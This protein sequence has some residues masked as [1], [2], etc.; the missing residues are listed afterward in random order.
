METNWKRVTYVNKH[1]RT[2]HTIQS[3]KYNEDENIEHI[4]PR[5]VPLI[6]NEHKESEYNRPSRLT[7][8]GYNKRVGNYNRQTAVIDYATIERNI[9]EGIF[10]NEINQKFVNEVID[11][12]QNKK[13]ESGQSMTQKD[14]A[15]ACSLPLAVIRDFEAGN[16]NLSSI[17]SVK[18]KKALDIK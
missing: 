18:I 17:D 15:N 3:W 10:D 2:L 7:S 16:C 6:F 1:K 11:A 4:D 14:L 13:L 12:R 9:D 5:F 8:D